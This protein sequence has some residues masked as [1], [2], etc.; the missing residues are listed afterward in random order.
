VSLVVVTDRCI[1][2]FDT[3]SIATPLGINSVARLWRNMC[4]VNPIPVRL[5]SRVT[6]LATVS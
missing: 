4:G 5:R 1:N 3:T 6:S 2:I